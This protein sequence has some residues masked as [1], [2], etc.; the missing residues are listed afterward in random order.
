M[1][2]AV[3]SGGDFKVTEGDFLHTLWVHLY[4]KHVKDMQLKCDEI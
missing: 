3:F 4:I 1:L 2:T